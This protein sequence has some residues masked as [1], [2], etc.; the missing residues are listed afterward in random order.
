MDEDKFN[1]GGYPLYIPATLSE[2]YDL[3]GSMRLESPTFRNSM[4]PL[5]DLE[6]TF[7]ELVESFALVRK[8]TGEERY[9][10]LLDLAARMRVEFEGDQEETNGGTARG[11]ALLTEIE[12]IIQ[13]VRNRRSKARLKDD[14][15][16]VSGD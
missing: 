2:I 11:L 16:E 4:M 15:G 1:P 5:Q 12:G 10:R 8:K 6:T 9:A 3:L 14:D 13:D 7:Y